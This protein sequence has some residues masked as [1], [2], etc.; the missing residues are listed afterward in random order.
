MSYSICLGLNIIQALSG[1]KV[2]IIYDLQA[3]KAEKRKERGKKQ[4]TSGRGRSGSCAEGGT[5]DFRNLLLFRQ[6]SSSP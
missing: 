4:H 3:K 1:T 2:T 6:R 5:I